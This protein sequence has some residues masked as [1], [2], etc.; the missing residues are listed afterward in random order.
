LKGKYKEKSCN[1]CNYN[2]FE[3]NCFVKNFYYICKVILF[4][5]F[6]NNHLGDFKMKIKLFLTALLIT[7]LA[8]TSCSEDNPVKENEK[9][10]KKISFSEYSLAGTAC[11]WTPY[12]LNGDRGA[13]IINSNEELEKYIICPEDSKYP[14]IDF[15]EQSLLLVLGATV[16]EVNYIDFELLLLQEAVDKYV[17]N[18]NIPFDMR[19]FASD[20]EHWAVSIIV[21]KIES[22]AIVKLNVNYEQIIEK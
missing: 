15:S 12:F 21:P 13:L 2:N 6:I 18:V 7:A 20:S 19:I 4:N 14:E 8:F 16:Y 5:F 3:Y 9:K 10:V 17:L 22:E 1:F 11:H